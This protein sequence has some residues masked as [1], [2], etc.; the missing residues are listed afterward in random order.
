MKGAISTSMDYSRAEIIVDSSDGV[1]D[2][3]SNSAF[4][5]KESRSVGERFVNRH[6]EGP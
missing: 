6:L 2:I 3:R 5:K 4:G 1:R